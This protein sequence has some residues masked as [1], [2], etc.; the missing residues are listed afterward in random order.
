MKKTIALICTIIA[1]ICG[2]AICVT[3]TGCTTS[4][5]DCTF[6]G[7]VDVRLGTGDVEIERTKP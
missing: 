7:P 4:L 3:Q 1:L 5:N 6:T 2:T